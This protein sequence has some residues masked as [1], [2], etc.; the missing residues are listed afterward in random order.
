MLLNAIAD[1]SSDDRNEDE[2]APNEE[3][4]RSARNLIAGIPPRLIGRPLV[5]PFYGEV[6]LT[7]NSGSKQLVLMFF[8]DRAPLVHRYPENI[9]SIE[10]ATPDRV[11]HWLNWL[12]E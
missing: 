10:E 2:P 4:I 9:D 12:N 1:I 6:H 5:S 8:P 7:W 11:I 3:T